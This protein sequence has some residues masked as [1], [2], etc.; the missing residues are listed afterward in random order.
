MVLAKACL[1]IDLDFVSPVC[2]SPLTVLVYTDIV[3]PLGLCTSSILTLQHDYPVATD[4]R[5]LVC[6]DD[7]MEET[8]LGP[9]GAF[10]YYMEYP[11]SLNAFRMLEDNLDDWLAEE[12]ENYLDDEYLVFDC[13]IDPETSVSHIELFAH[14]P[15]LWNFMNH[16][17]HK[18]FNI[19]VVYLLD[20]QFITDVTKYI[21]RCIASLYAMV[22]L[23]LPH[24]NILSKMDLVAKKSDI[25]DYL[26]PEAW[27][28]LSELIQYTA[29]KFAKLN[30]VLAELVS[31]INAV[32]HAR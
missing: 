25:E 6:L 5:E 3:R 22:Q 29:P 12:L 30:K 4:I 13:P 32:K 28:L 27:V 17:K 19:C 9:N 14:V 7:V 8:G 26:N 1:F 15:V 10:I 16:L 31:S 21:S 24:V 11:F 2:C 23:E 20:S 18:I